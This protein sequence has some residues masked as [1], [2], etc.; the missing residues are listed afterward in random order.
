MFVSAILVT[1]IQFIF[2]W[3]QIT[4]FGENEHIHD[5]C[6]IEIRVKFQKLPLDLSVKQMKNY[7]GNMFDTESN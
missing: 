2:I 6:L 4:H 1:N 3:C 5:T 7:Y